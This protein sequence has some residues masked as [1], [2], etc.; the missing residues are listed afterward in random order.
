MIPLCGA[1]AGAILFLAFRKF[2]HA[3]ATR[4]W[5]RR[6]Q[7]YVLSLYLF[8]D[9]PAQSLRAFGRIARAN[10]ALL[11]HALPP[12]IVAAPLVAAIAFWL[13]GWVARTPLTDGRA[14][15]LTARVPANCDPR[16]ETPAW[17]RSD[18]PP[19]RVPSANEVSWR[20]RAAAPGAGTV[21][22]ACGATHLEAAVDSTRG[23]RSW[24]SAIRLS[25]L[26]AEPWLGWFSVIAATVAW[27]LLR[28]FP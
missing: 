12:L 3:A 10:A 27:A 16:L 11:L 6:R 4:T 22:I 1:L 25:Q 15:V 5:K 2:T 23:V 7:A 21:G 19:V 9:E 20:V 18:S 17:L 8:G 13:N 26:P 24:N 28:F 14:A